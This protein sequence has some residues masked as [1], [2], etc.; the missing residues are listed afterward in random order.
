MEKEVEIKLSAI[1]EIIAIHGIKFRKNIFE[2]LVLLKEA[3]PDYADK[4]Q[5]RF[6][7]I[8][9]KYQIDLYNEIRVSS[10]D[11]NKHLEQY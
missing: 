4:I 6:D 1:E 8:C 2:S 5:K 7:E 3:Y 10:E 9:K 11:I